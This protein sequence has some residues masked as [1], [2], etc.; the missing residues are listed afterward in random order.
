MNT[1]PKVVGYVP[2]YNASK[3]IVT[4]L[5]KLADQTYPN[6]EIIVCD[7]ASTDNTFEIC[8]EFV[9]NHPNFSIIKNE[10][11]LGW[12][13]TSDQLWKQA[14][15]KSTYCFFNAHD[16]HPRSNFVEHLVH[17]L[18]SRPNTVLA[19]P[20]MRNIYQD[21]VIIDSFYNAASD[22][23]DVVKRTL[24]VAKRNIHHWWASYHGLHRSSA[25]RS[26]IPL[27]ALP[28]GE[29]EFSVDLVW[30]IKMSLQGEFVTSN[31]ILLEKNYLPKSV[32]DT[33]KHS[34]YNRLALWSAILNE[35][36]KSSIPQKTK[37]KIWK[38]L[39]SLVGSK[40]KLRI[41]SN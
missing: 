32:S 36:R 18:E 41:S 20:G 5:T 14:S 35:I 7:D 2:T 19:I 22:E 23:V 34:S 24:Q 25:V 3:F 30:I 13:K 10:V 26:I 6:L 40:L 33:W 21:G 31:E 39:M 11:N 27:C 38:K 1:V 4:T 28:F 37:L 12:L 9:K 17:L 16:D 29:P 15:E 8:L